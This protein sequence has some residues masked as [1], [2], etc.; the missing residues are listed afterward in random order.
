MFEDQRGMEINCEIGV[1]RDLWKEEVER[2]MKRVKK[3]ERGE[4]EEEEKRERG[5]KRKREDKRDS[6]RMGLWLL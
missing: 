3:E 4:I 5:R 2:G 6:A 1:E